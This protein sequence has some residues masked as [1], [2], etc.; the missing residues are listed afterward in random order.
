MSLGIHPI[1]LIVAI[2]LLGAV[3]C[4]AFACLTARWLKRGI[5][6]AVA[7]LLLAP[8]GFVLA[9]LKPELVDARFRTYKGLYRNI[10]V[11]MTRSEV[12]HLVEQHY[13][14]G[15]KRL[16]PRV[17]EDSDANLDFFMNPETSTEPNCE[18]IFLQMQ[19]D[20]VVKKSYTA[21]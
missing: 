5:L 9:M 18:G 7:L 17:L 15:G 8:S 21:D 11:G 2:T 3:V 10:Q 6:L 12:M 1:F 19:R 4:I 13:P 16:A 20:K 14:P